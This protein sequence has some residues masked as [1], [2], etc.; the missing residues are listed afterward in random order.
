MRSNLSIHVSNMF[1]LIKPN[2]YNS[3]ICKRTKYVCNQNVKP[4]QCRASVWKWDE[5]FRLIPFL[6]H[7]FVVYLTLLV[8]DWNRIHCPFSV[9][10]FYSVLHSNTHPTMVFY[11][12]ILPI[13]HEYTHTCIYILNNTFV[14]LMIKL[15]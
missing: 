14:R 1:S 5:W 15:Y 8:V 6:R 7:T 13:L 4:T 2:F 3:I 12:P 9:R 11:R 10:G